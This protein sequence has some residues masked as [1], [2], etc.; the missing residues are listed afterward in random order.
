MEPWKENSNVMNVMWQLYST[1]YTCGK[2]WYTVKSTKPCWIN[3]SKKLRLYRWASWIWRDGSLT[4]PLQFY[5]SLPSFSLLTSSLPLFAVFLVFITHGVCKN[6]M[7]YRD[8]SGR[9]PVKFF[10]G[11]ALHAIHDSKC[12]LSDVIFWFCVIWWHACQMFSV[13]TVRRLKIKTW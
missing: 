10:C 5:F 7:G 6:H 12:Y 2:Y 11:I 3:L 13:F 8:S 9:F 4:R 1:I